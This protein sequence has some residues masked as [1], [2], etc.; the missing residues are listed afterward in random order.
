MK[1]RRGRFE[2]ATRRKTSAV[3]EQWEQRGRLGYAS[4]KMF[5]E[6]RGECEE[7]NSSPQI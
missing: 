3:E 2:V 7:L 1:Y 4:F 6:V 5:S